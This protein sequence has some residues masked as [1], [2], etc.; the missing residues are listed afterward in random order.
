VAAE[1]AAWKECTNPSKKEKLN[2]QIANIK[3]VIKRKPRVE[4]QGASFFLVDLRY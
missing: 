1:W 4:R 2:Y 3:P